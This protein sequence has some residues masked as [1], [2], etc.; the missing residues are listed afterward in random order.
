M[1]D[2]THPGPRKSTRLAGWDYSRPGAYFFTICTHERR[3]LF[4]EVRGGEMV[5]N[6]LGKIAAEAWQEIPVHHPEAV[7]DE[8]IVMPNHVH[9]ILF[10]RPTAE[11]EDTAGRVPTRGFGGSEAGTLSTIVGSFKAT[12]TRRIREV[13]G[14]P[15]VVW[16]PRMMDHVIRDERDLLYHRRYTR[17]NAAK[18]EQDREHPRFHES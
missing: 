10:L 16:Q 18:W 8:F 7:L 15:V 6:D 14:M 11:K 17:F 5:L 1:T 4:G 3:C 13:V 2:P 12:V 9:G